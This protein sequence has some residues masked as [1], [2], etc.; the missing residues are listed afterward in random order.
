MIAELLSSSRHARRHA[1]DDLAPDRESAYAARD[2]LAFDA[3][4]SVRARAAFF[5]AHA[6]SEIAAPALRDALYDEMPLVRH[7]ATRALATQSDLAAVPRLTRMSA[8][9]PIWWVRRA[10]IVSVT[11]LSGQ[12]CVPMLRAALEDP[13]W[14]VRHAAVRALIA[15]GEGDLGPATSERSAGA[16]AYV[17]KRLGIVTQG[18]AGPTE[19][20]NSIVAQLDPDPAVVTAR[21]DRGE[22]VSPAFLVECLGD[23][24]EALR[25]TARKR[26]ARSHDARAL[27]LALLWLEDVRIPHAAETVVSLLDG[28]D[29]EDVAPLLDRALTTETPGAACWAA[30]YV[31]LTRDVSRLP[32]LLELARAER[33]QIRRAAT[34]ALGAFDDDAALDALADALSDADEDVVRAAAGVLLE[35][36]DPRAQHALA[37]VSVDTP[38]ALLRRVLVAAADVREDLPALRDASRDS[39]AHVRAIA[40]G[41]RA[42]RDDIGDDEREHLMSDP[43]PWVRRAVVDE[44]HAE[45]VLTSD[46]QPSLRRAAFSLVSDRRRASALAAASDDPW[47][48]T[49][50]AALL[51]ARGLL[52]LSRDRSSAVRAAAADALEALEDEVVADV[53]RDASSDEMRI[54][55]Y[56]HLSRGCDEDALARLRGARETESAA[57][58]AWLDDA[59]SAFGAA[60][61]PVTLV[62]RTRP[63]PTHVRALGA[64][65]VR[66][67]PL[68]ISGVGSLP[69]VAYAEALDAGCNLFFW[70]PR[71]HALGRMLT[72]HRDAQLI[73]GTYHASERAIVSDV[74][75]TLRRLRRD[76]LDVFLLFW[77]RSPARVDAA[78]FAV[79]SRLKKEG[80]V[81][82]IGFS[83]HHRDLAREAIAARGWDVVMTRHS[84]AHPGAEDALFPLAHTKNVGVLTFSALSYGRILTDSI[85]AADAYRYCLSQE[86]V[87]AC[88]SAPRARS[89]LREN[90]EVLAR[91]TLP[92]ARQAELRAHGRVVREDSRDFA[93]TVRRHPL[94]LADARPSVERLR[95]WLSQE[96][97]RDIRAEATGRST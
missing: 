23:P 13:F 58:Q 16:I 18:L 57:V 62:E 24:H 35:H 8:E 69:T 3:D 74:E 65:G 4:G 51:D 50:A 86:G 75:R 38:D 82:A 78:T 96:D 7:A 34:A 29:A 80:K 81:R 91:P 49:R 46:P 40:I 27:E 15:L 19:V 84:A 22:A 77:V 10:A 59:L 79:L 44:P 2:V 21:V 36:R 11:S 73:A 17:Q 56:A 70:E 20:L 66:A 48:R 26:L 53:L 52:V 92:A 14:R 87:S 94:T 43:D 63:A 55:A 37:R 45:Q 54:A 76:A 93:H 90:L 5:L 64:T 12:A 72:G 61:P 30:S 95:D 1:F 67:S 89:E 97:E 88:L 85:P 42:R 83:T 68:V 60:R 32:R 33:P 6:P 31:A 28:L 71:Y 25:V 9:D 39:D 41:A 47:L